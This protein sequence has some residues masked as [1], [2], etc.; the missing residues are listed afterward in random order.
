MEGTNLVVT[1]QSI[2]EYFTNLVVAVKEGNLNALEVFARVKDLEKLSAD[3]K[4]QIEADAMIEA[5]NH[6]S[7]TFSFAGYK[8][9]KTEGRRMIDYT[10]IPEYAELKARMKV[11]EEKH[12]NALDS[13]G[14]LVDEGT[15]EIIEKPLVTYSKSSLSSS[16]K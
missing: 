11:L 16:K 12:K 3:T 13:K 6:G 9:T 2:E 8:F 10:N 4:K 15:G 7:K 5:E 14:V 1:Q